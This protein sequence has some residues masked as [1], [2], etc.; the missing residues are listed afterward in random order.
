MNNHHLLTAS[1]M[2]MANDGQ[3]L[4]ESQVKVAAAPSGLDLLV[5]ASQ[6]KSKPTAE[7]D[8]ESASNKDEDEDPSSD[9]DDEK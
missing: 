8:G 5:A 7:A 9:Y 6:V 2:A 4:S 1:S 3:P